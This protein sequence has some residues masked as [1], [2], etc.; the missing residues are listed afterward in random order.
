MPFV[1]YERLAE[2]RRCA[3]QKENDPTETPEIPDKL[4]NFGADCI[5]TETPEV[6]DKP[7][8]S[9]RPEIVERLIA[10]QRIAI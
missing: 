9:V 1:L 4:Q 6:P 7:E 8:I 10:A 5:K 2:C 3:E